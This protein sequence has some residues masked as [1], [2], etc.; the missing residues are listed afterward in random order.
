LIKHLTSVEVGWFEFAFAGT[1]VDVPGEEIQPGDTV[2]AAV[3]AYQDVAQANNPIVLGSELA[4]RCA[5]APTTLEP[6]SLRWVLVHLVEETA[7]HAGHADILRE[8]FD[9]QTGR[10]ASPRQVSRSL[11]ERAGD[12]RRLIAV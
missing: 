10:S 8:Q 6:L 12:R 5:R 7:R 11:R 9:G 4:R 2:A 1:D 3:A